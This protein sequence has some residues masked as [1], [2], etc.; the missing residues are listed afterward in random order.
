[1]PRTLAPVAYD[2]QLADRIRTR[3]GPDPSVSEQ[4]MFGGLAFLIDGNMAV[5]VSGQGGLMVRVPAEETDALIDRT[6]A[7]PMEMKGRPIRGWVRVASDAVRTKRQLGSWVD[8]GTG[9]ART[10][11][12]KG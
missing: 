6:A 8:R 4:R 3:L 2:E 9:Y 1:V 12:T 7:E 5:G 11:P 10:L